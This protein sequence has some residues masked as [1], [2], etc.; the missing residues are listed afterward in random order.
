MRVHRAGAA[1][2]RPQGN[3][4]AA[5]ARES[6]LRADQKPHMRRRHPAAERRV[7]HNME[8]LVYQLRWAGVRKE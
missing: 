6:L 3:P 5:G 1:P 4:E 7:C 2:A 8:L